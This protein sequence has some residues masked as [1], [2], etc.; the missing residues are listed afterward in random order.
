MAGLRHV[1]GFTDY[2]SLTAEISAIASAVVAGSYAAARKRGKKSLPPLAVFALGKFGTEEL[3]FDADLDLLFVAGDA[4]D[5]VRP[6]QE[7]MAERVLA[8]VTASPSGERMYEAD[9]RLRPEGKSAPL[10]V[11]A[12]S[13]AKYISTRASLWERQSPVS[14]SWPE[15]VPSEDTFP[16]WLM[17]GC[18]A[19]PSP[20]GGGRRSLQ[21]AVRWKRG[22][23]SAE[24]TSRT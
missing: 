12:A 23:G 16:L 20:P 6:L 11:E 8:G 9:V 7:Q 10:V 19:R 15:T 24:G 3:A 13:Y 2:D 1:L 14:G 5:S 17:R 4:G 18:T 21:C 22:A